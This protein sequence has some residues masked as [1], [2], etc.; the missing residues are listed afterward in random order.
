MRDKS[1]FKLRILLGFFLL[2]Y[3][4]LVFQTETEISKQ[5]KKKIRSGKPKTK[6]SRGKSLGR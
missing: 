6:L 4:V 1:Y 5:Q 3:K 2:I